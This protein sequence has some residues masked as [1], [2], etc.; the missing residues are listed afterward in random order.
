METT[1]E[2]MPQARDEGLVIQE[3]DDEVLVYDLDRHRSHCLNR[4]AALVWRHCD[5]KTSIAKMS[6]L[7]Q[8]ELSAP[9]GEEAV[10]LAL[11]RLGRAHLLRERLP[12]PMNAAR[13]SRRALVRK[14]ALV[15]GLA[16]ISSIGVPTPAQ[17]GATCVTTCSNGK[18]GKC[19]C[20]NRKICD[21]TSCVGATC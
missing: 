12:L 6:A 11:D 8:R 18:T 3:L 7:L 1:Q 13:T 14:L 21:G 4:T 15:G 5:G 9:A 17:A 2:P 19:C 16:L 20:S 10:W